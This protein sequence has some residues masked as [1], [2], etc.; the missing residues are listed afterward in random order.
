MYL[1]ERKKKI[2]FNL[3]KNETQK[4]FLN[5]KKME[6]KIKEW[7]VPGFLCPQARVLWFF[8][9]LIITIL[10]TYFSLQME[11]QLAFDDKYPENDPSI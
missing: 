11:E 5:D 1:I 2:I 7:F 3:I 10:Q 6:P 9:F 8:L 4:Y